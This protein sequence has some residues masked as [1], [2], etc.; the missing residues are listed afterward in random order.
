M[1]S[2][3]TAYLYRLTTDSGEFLKWGVTQDMAK[4]YSLKYMADKKM[5]EYASG[6]RANMI[7]MERGLVETQPGRLNLE[8]WAGAR[9][10]G[11]P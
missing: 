9:L 4:R 7:R 8:R 11:Q 1:N 6:T 2:T 3:K 10:G 5:F